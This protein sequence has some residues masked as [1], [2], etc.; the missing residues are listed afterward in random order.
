MS[1]S[2]TVLRAGTSGFRGTKDE[3]TP[4]H[5]FAA[6]VLYGEMLGAGKRVTVGHDNRETAAKLA[7]AA[8]DGFRS[9]GLH[10]DHLG[11]VSTGVFSTRTACL[12]P[13]HYAG[14]ILITG[15]HM[16]PDRIGIIPIDDTAAYCTH[17]VTNRIEV[18]FSA[19]QSGVWGNARYELSGS[20][21]RVDNAAS[22]GV[23]LATLWDTLRDPELREERFKV[24]LDAGNG[25]TGDPARILLEGLG[26]DV[27]VLNEEPQFIPDRPS[28]VTPEN[29][30]VAVDRMREGDYD[31]GACFDGDGD[32]VLFIAPDGSTYEDD[33]IAA[34]FAYYELEPVRGTDPVVVTPVTAGSLVSEVCKRFGGRVEYCRVG[35]PDTGRAIKACGAHVVFAY[36]AAAR[37]FC[38]PAQFTF[39]DGV[40]AVARMLAIMARTGKSLQQLVADVAADFCTFFPAEG[41]IMLEDARKADVVA[42]AYAAAGDAFREAEVIDID[43]LRFNFTDSSW[44]LLRPSGTEPKVR[45]YAKARTSARALALAKQARKLFENAMRS[46]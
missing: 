27:V 21:Y 28:E 40:Y 18:G 42:K 11:M 5:A 3:V 36:E 15:S 12:R 25:T 20:L 14:G 8:C 45:Y 29:C 17:N 2:L 9:E 46:A 41:S 13:N 16:P 6:A 37:K 31:L 32:R 23:Y 33:I 38:F 19:F 39:Y 22:L 1:K 44:V 4:D 26:C 43:G 30:D 10:V 34:I 7:S 24:L 35:Q